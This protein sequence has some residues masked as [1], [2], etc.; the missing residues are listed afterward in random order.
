MHVV[1]AWAGHSGIS[2]TA[3]YYLQ[4]SEADFVRAATERVDIGLPRKDLRVFASGTR[5]KN[6]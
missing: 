4:V 5:R 2:T 6:S 1:R 3:M